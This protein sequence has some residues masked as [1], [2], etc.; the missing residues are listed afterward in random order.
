MDVPHAGN[1]R[2]NTPRELRARGLVL[3]PFPVGPSH[4]DALPAASTSHLSRAE[5]GAGGGAGVQVTTVSQLDRPHPGLRASGVEGQGPLRDQAPGPQPFHSAPPQGG[6][7]DAELRLCLG[8]V[9]LRVERPT[10]LPGPAGGPHTLRT[11][12]SGCGIA[13]GPQGKTPLPADAAANQDTRPTL[14]RPTDVLILSLSPLSPKTFL[15][16]IKVTW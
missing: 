10:P 1:T 14:C 12:V 15:L 8:V 13:E 7:G 4:L 2:E 3:P 6:E 16:M 5:G 9:G 11:A